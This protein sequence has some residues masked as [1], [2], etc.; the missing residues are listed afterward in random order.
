MAITVNKNYTDTAIA[1]AVDVSK[2]LAKINFESDFV[3]GDLSSNE[4][5]IHNLTSPI[6][7]PETFRFGISRP[8]NVFKGTGVDPSFYPPS[9]QGVQ[10][11]TRVE[12]IWTVEDSGDPSFKIALPVSAHTVVRVPNS[13]YITASDVQTLLIRLLSLSYGQNASTNER[14]TG[15]LHG[16]LLPQE[17]K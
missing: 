13:E 16:S 4:A 6:S 15:L 8:T 2:V 11:L 12:E 9:R 1:G 17:V 14:I 3:R 10:I 7:F 5:I